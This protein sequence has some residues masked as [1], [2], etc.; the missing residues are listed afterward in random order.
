MQEELRFSLL[1]IGS[2]FILAILAHGIWNI[3]KN[4]QSI[5]MQRQEPPEWEDDEEYEDD[6]DFHDDNQVDETEKDPIAVDDD[7]EIDPIE[8]EFDETGVGKVRVVSKN[9]VPPSSDEA[10]S[11]PVEEIV[12]DPEVEQLSDPQSKEDKSSGAAKKEE[13]ADK[14]ESKLDAQ[15]LFL[16]LQEV[17]GSDIS[18]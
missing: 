3:R 13:R 16:L 7:D 9:E 17:V 2:I 18:R 4:K 1:L 6:N 12:D 5:A 15:L 8:Q 14:E 11:E 10:S